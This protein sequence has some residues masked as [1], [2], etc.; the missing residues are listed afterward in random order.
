MTLVKDHV[1]TVVEQNPIEWENSVYPK[2]G[3]IAQN[4]TFS[5]TVTI[6]GAS[7]DRPFIATMAYTDPPGSPG[8]ANVLV[9]NLD[10][11]V[12]VT[13]KTGN[14]S[15][16]RLWGNGVVGG[17]PDNNIEYVR[18]TLSGYA[19]VTV[20]VFA[21]SVNAGI[22][23][24]NA[25][26]G[27]DLERKIRNEAYNAQLAERAARLNATASNATAETDTKTVVKQRVDTA[28]TPCQ[29][30]ALVISGNLIGAEPSPPSP[31]PAHRKGCLRQP[32]FSDPARPVVVDVRE[33]AICT[34]PPP[35]H[36][37]T[38]PTLTSRRCRR[39]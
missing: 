39:T 32:A 36:H 2:S 9:N 26:A 6:S 1:M 28:P 8:A 35:L 17:D 23:T 20:S 18:M 14:Q 3:S 30:F 27:E 4:E 25:P 33:N 22:T 31:P 24:Y 34:S 10:L 19:V 13:A 11:S 12:Q 5:Y 37:R 16:I 38:L 21:R 15:V 29:P 7:F